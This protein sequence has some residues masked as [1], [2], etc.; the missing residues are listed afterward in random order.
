MNNLHEVF[1]VIRSLADDAIHSRCRNIGLV[2]LAAVRA[3]RA[4]SLRESACSYVCLAKNLLLI[5]NNTS[6]CLSPG[7]TADFLCP[8][9]TYT[10]FTF[11]ATQLKHLRYLST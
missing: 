2:R 5:R 3:Y 1:G 6:I 4:P 9:L 11:G 7:T 8:C 10:L